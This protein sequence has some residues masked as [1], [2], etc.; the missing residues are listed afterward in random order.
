MVHLRLLSTAFETVGAAAKPKDSVEAKW[1]ANNGLAA[2]I[3][4]YKMLWD[5]GNI[6]HE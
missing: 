4:V 1:G 3:K 6:L 2:R 5:I